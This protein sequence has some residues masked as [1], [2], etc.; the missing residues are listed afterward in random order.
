MIVL[1]IPNDVSTKVTKLS[2][3]NDAQGMK[4]LMKE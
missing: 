4:D 1:I 3:W 2:Y